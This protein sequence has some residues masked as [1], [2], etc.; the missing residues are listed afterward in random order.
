MSGLPAF[1]GRPVGQVGIIV[2]DLDS[3]L[4]R[5]TQEWGIG[6][7]RCWTYGPATVPELGY[8]GRPGEYE[9]RIA[10]CGS[11]PQIEL[12]E[13]VRGPSIYHEWLDE[14]G[15]GLHHL[16][17]YVPSL[18]EALEEMAGAGH[19]PVQWGRGY[20]AEGDGGYAYFDV[21]LLLGLHLELLELP[22]RRVEAE[23]V[24]PA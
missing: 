4:E 7:W 14:H 18:G 12:I 19:Q 15:E 22:R 24:Y 23:R 9:M 8:R 17:V 3:A 6:P 11:K 21:R 5:Y 16:G 20:G 10:L 2:R 1:A 13:P